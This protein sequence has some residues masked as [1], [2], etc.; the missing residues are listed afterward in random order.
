MYT[1]HFMSKTSCQT[2][3]MSSVGY[4]LMGN[5]RNFK[6]ANVTSVRETYCF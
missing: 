4:I 2:W 5:R 3:H 1:L 6:S